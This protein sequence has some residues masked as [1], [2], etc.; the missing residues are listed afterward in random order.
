MIATFAGEFD[1]AADESFMDHLHHIFRVTQ[2]I[3]VTVRGVL[4]RQV[5]TMNAMN[6]MNDP[7]FMLQLPQVLKLGLPMS[8]S[9]KW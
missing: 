9:Q 6:A 5:T 1:A 8:T 7:S 3:F 4:C 2:R